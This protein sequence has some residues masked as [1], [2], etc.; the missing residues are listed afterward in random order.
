MMDISQEGNAVPNEGRHHDSGHKIEHVLVDGQEVAVHGS[1]FTGATL[2]AAV[3]KKPCAYELIAV[4][5]HRENQVVEP[6][7][8]IDLN[9]HDLDGFITAH[10]EI[11]DITVNG[12][13]RQIAR[14]GHT[15]G[16][17]LALVDE[18]AE[19]SILMED[20]NG[21]LRRVP[22]DQMVHIR[23]CEAFDSQVRTGSSS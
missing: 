17:I 6:D 9:A 15:I 14:G 4:F 2:L 10:R 11:V 22:D 8:H 12:E 1:D 23:G 19:G 20:K 13:K 5:K 3:D 16:Q 21:E 7:E 18:T